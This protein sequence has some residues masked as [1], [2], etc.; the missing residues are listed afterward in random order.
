MVRIRLTPANYHR[1]HFFDD[2]IVTATKPIDGHLY[3]VS[4]L[5]LGRVARLYCQ[6]KRELIS[7]SSENFGEVI[8][9]E[10]GATF[11]GS[12]VHCFQAGESVHRGQQAGYFQPGGSLVLLFFK[13]AAFI[14]DSAILSQTA[15]GFESSIQAGMP[16]GLSVSSENG[17]VEDQ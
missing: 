17:G 15:A 10:V 2:G 11:A 3:T 13:E 5:A 6:N 1:I 4:P 16:I 14:P 9:V 12:I 8:I 7:F